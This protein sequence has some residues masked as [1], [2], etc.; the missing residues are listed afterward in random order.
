VPALRDFD[1]G[2]S[3]LAI[4]PSREDLVFHRANLGEEDDR[5]LVEGFGKVFDLRRGKSP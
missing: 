2:S 3:G 4:V 5:W 1:T